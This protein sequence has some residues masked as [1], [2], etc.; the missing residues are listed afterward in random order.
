MTMD[1]NPAWSARGPILLGT[2]TL[3]ILLGGFGVWSLTATI[4]GAIVSSG[5]I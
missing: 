5:Q 2:I 3:A 1:P 4:A